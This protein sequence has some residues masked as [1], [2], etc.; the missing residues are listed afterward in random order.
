MVRLVLLLVGVLAWIGVAGTAVLVVNAWQEDN[1]VLA[2]I[3]IAG[4][5]IIAWVI[6]EYVTENVFEKDESEARHGDA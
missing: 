5:V 6:G 4:A 2:F 3:P 1:Q